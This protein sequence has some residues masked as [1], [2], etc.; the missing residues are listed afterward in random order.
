MAGTS[1][2]V[3]RCGSSIASASSD[4]SIVEVGK[5][6][7]DQAAAGSMQAQFGDALCVMKPDLL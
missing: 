4:P 2:H 6:T 5:L 7:F 1:M 3:T